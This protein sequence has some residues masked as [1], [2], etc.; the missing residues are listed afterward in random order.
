MKCPQCAADNRPGRRFCGACGAAIPSPCPSCGFANEPDERF[1]GG[2][3]KS[4]A[5]RPPQTPQAYTPK[6]LADRILTSR[7]AMEGERKQVSVLFCDLVDSSRLAATLEPE[8]MHEIMN[9]VLQLMAKAVHRYEGTV[10]Q[11][12][13]DGL[14]A[15]FGAPIALEDH[16][17][18]AAHAALTI[19]DTVAGS[20]GDLH[21]EQGIDLRLRIG[22]NTGP[23][24]V[25]RIGDDLRMDY[26]A[27]GDTTHLAARLQGLAEA[28]G[29]FV[30]E[31]TYRAVEGYVRADALGPLP[32]KGRAKAVRVW[33]V[34]GLRRRRSRLQ[35]GIER[36]LSPLAGRQYELGLI[37]GCWEGARVGH[38]Q[39]VNLFG[40]AGVG[41]SRLLFEFR[42][43]LKDKP[44]PWL[45][46]QC[47]AYAQG[48]P[49]LPL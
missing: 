43:S 46:G 23:V 4:L 39:V 40:E 16:A 49:Y 20:G 6:H 48:T 1:C 31:A 33:N 47:S 37:M 13:G 36:G 32:I 22:I 5:E 41:K 24:V 19:L 27:V 42:Q 28:G 10:N 44:V 2:C 25:G 8:T 11:F 21:R 34:T 26:T 3:G 29:V 12:L 15:L 7:A 14:M 30:S 35:I 9:R 18:R 38:G 45:E 17:L